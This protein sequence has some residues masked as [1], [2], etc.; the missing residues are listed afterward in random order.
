MSQQTAVSHKVAAV[1]SGVIM[2]GCNFIA[3]NGTDDDYSVL[4]CDTACC[5]CDL[6]P[7]SSR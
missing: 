2:R 5:D 6:L 4:G 1:H 3:V 7:P